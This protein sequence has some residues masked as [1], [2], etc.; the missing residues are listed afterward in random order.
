MSRPMPGAVD[1][2]HSASSPCPF[3]SYPL[4]LTRCALALAW[5]KDARVLDALHGLISS[6]YKNIEYCEFMAL[7]RKFLHRYTA[8]FQSLTDLTGTIGGNVTGDMDPGSQNKM[9]GENPIA[10]P[11]PDARIPW[12]RDTMPG[13]QH[14][15]SNTPRCP[16]A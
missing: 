7:L 3:P 6:E 14:A 1:T 13:H 2:A 4:L 15:C 5:T 8:N 12:R 16:A 9:L 10:L 11:Q